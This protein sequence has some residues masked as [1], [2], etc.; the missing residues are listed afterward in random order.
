MWSNERFSSMR[1]ITWSTDSSPAID[2]AFHPM[3]LRFSQP[4]P[5]GQL[6]RRHPAVGTSKV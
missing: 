5:E 3:I 1:R 2:A 6:D 4:E